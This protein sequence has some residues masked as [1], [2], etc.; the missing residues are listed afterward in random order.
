[1]ASPHAKIARDGANTGMKIM[2]A[3]HAMKNIMVLRQPYRSWAYALTRSPANWPTSDE[4][5]KPDCHAGVMRV[6]PEPGSN[7]PKR[8]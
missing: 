5:D 3:I 8:F 7:C 2:T 4:F 1:M 6:C